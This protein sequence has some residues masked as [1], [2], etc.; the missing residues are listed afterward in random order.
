MKAKS[1]SGSV[2]L[3]TAVM[4]LAF[5]ALVSADMMI[6]EATATDAFEM[7]GQKVPAAADTSVTW[8]SEK[9]ARKDMGDTA[10]IIILVDK[11]VMYTLNHP[12][13]TYLEIPL[14]AFGDL[15]K[16]MSASGDEEQAAAAETVMKG[17]M[18]QMQL[19]VT[20]TPTEETKKIQKWNCKKYTVDTKMGMATVKSE[21]WATEDVKVDYET[22]QKIGSAFM[23]PMPGAKEALEEM[24]KIKG[25]TIHSAGTANMMGAQVTTTTEVLEVSEKSAPAGIFDLPEDYKKQ[26]GVI[27]GTR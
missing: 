13:K 4:F 8:L 17:M 3:L 27:P 2:A 16:L 9:R 5:P 10:S 7:M 12:A 20:V 15:S 18:A 21:I 22:L 11:N 23:A 25:L 24:K 6:R 19:K 14:D 1:W 26:E